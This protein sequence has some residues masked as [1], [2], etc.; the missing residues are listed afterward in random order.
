MPNGLFIVEFFNV[1]NKQQ[2]CNIWFS[3]AGVAEELTVLPQI[4]CG[5]FFAVGSVKEQW[6][7]RPNLPN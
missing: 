5:G 1:A 2:S 6:N 4:F 7:K 3:C